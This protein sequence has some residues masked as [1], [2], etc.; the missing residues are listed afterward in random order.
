MQKWERRSD[1]TIRNPQT[2]KCLEI[3]GFGSD[4]GTPLQIWECV[5]GDNQK[6]VLEPD[7]RIRNPKTSKCADSANL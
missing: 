6:W 5:G 3:A 7:G 1:G 2:G 4:D